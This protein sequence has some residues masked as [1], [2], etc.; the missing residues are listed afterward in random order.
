MKEMRDE[1]PLRYRYLMDRYSIIMFCGFLLGFVLM[2]ILLNEYFKDRNHII[3]II[4][5]FFCLAGFTMT[6]AY[7]H[8][9]FY[10]SLPDE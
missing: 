10:N 7:L 1:N 3:E 5:S 6:E 2:S 4:S 9:R 8:N